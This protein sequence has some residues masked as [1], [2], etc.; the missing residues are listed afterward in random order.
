MSHDP[1]LKLQPSRRSRYPAPHEKGEIEAR[2]RK[3]GAISINVCGTTELVQSVR[4][5]L[6]DGVGRLLDVLRETSALE[7]CKKRAGE[8]DV[9]TLQPAQIGAAVFSTDADRRYDHQVS[10]GNPYL[11]NV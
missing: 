11:M 5:S 6:S 10:H 4:C 9:L 1:F 7:I 8:S 3:G 2:G